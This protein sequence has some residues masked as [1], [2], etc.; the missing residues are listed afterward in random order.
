[1]GS[2]LTGGT[3]TW[4]IDRVLIQPK[5]ERRRYFSATRA[6]I[7]K[8]WGSFDPMR[9]W[10]RAL[11]RRLR[12]GA[13]GAAESSLQFPVSFGE[14]RRCHPPRPTSRAISGPRKSFL[15]LSWRVSAAKLKTTLE[16]LASFE[17][18]GLR[19]SFRIKRLEGCPGRHL[20]TD[21]TDEALFSGDSS[22]RDVCAGN[23]TSG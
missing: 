4:G 19:N 21:S 12:G 15:L 10:G 17:P 20:P 23:P 6:G 18:L 16:Y 22:I 11:R 14:H 13:G 7:F 2:L 1:V 8:G 5:M 9:I 3:R